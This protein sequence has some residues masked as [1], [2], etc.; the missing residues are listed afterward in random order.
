MVI[1]WHH[2]IL[3]IAGAAGGFAGGLTLIA[4]AALAWAAWERRRWEPRRKEE[5]E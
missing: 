5:D 1:D 2:A 3:A 4:V